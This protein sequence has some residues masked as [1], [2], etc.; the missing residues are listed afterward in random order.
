MKKEELQL[1]FT[2]GLNYRAMPVVNSTY[3][4]ENRTIDTVIATEAPALMIDWEKSNWNN[5]VLCREVLLCEPEAVEIPAN[6]QVPFL[7]AHWKWTSDDV[8]GSIRELK[9]ENQQVVGTV[10]ISSLE[11]RIATKISEGHL[12]DISAGYRTYKDYS[13]RIKPKE[14]ADYNGR[15]FENNYGDNLDLI[16]RTKWGL[17]EGSSVP[18]GADDYSKYRSDAS[19]QA[20]SER[21]LQNDISINSNNHKSQRSISMEN[22][23]QLTEEQIREQE[24]TRI[25]EIDSIAKRFAN[26]FKGGTSELERIK[27]EAIQNNRTADY[28]RSV[29]FDNYD[30][31]KPVETPPSHIGMGEK[32][33]KEFSI[34]RAINAAIEERTGDGKGWANAPHE[35]EMIDQVR[36]QLTDLDGYT[37]KGIPLPND[38]LT[39]R[40]AP[41]LG[42]GGKR[43]ATMT[44][45]TPGDGGY[46]VGTQH[47]G[48]EYVEL[49][50]NRMVTGQ[51][52]V[53][54]LTGL[55]QS[56]SIPKQ[57]TSPTL[58]F[59]A[60]SGS[61][62]VTKMTFGQIPL[63]P[64]EG[65]A[66][67]SYSRKLF[68]QS[69]P[70]VDALVIDDILKVA[71]LGKDKAILH[72]SGTYEPTG[73]AAASGLGSVVGTDLDWAKCVEFET[74]VATA[75]AD[76]NTLNF[77]GN[78]QVRGLLKTRTKTKDY[79]FFLI[80]ED[81][82][83]N[84]YNFLAT[85]QA[86][87]G[88]LFFGDFSQIWLAEWGVVD[89]LVNP[90]KDESGDVVVTVFCAIDVGIRVDG[91][92]SI[93]DNVT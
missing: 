69:I 52:G 14:K 25:S 50:R 20:E 63:T 4:N 76:V 9:V 34:T 75:N 24:R 17:K 48:S 53:R 27:K 42:Y 85:N 19:I 31:T 13:L 64:K 78:P 60:E 61:G 18:I 92:F 81:N 57:L 88:Y 33:L 23:A 74:D 21:F 22:T 83:L 1:L 71:A 73:L 89:V 36:K 79:P 84:G 11:E 65:R 15:S 90:F 54:M 80:N 16:V 32:D 39:P 41:H 37:I 56:I 7:D 38:V 46:L 26:N 10:H 67:M 29:V 70:A 82:K 40:M 3:S 86:A 58:E 6:R 62:S 28:F 49:M 93:S 12:T 55:R 30:D 51:A 87:N 43:A 91:A 5:I 2:R 45:G 44:V 72:G 68:L 77:I 59:V 8:K 47:L 66:S 35:K